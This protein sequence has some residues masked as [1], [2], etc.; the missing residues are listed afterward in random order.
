MSVQHNL[1]FLRALARRLTT[2]TRTRVLIV[3]PDQLGARALAAAL[4]KQ[5]SASFAATASEA[6]A[7]LAAE[8]FD[9][10]VTELHLPD[11]AGIDLLFNLRQGTTTDSLLLMAMATHASVDE[12]IAV[13]RAGADDCLIKP[14]TPARFADHVQR[15]ALARATLRTNAS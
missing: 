4:P 9:L 2:S 13:F 8:S 14:L 5:F 7:A 3:D 11:A 12:K 15:L 6:R 10:V 1:P